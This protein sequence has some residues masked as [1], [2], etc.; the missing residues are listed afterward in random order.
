MP[1]T[2]MN[3]K[4]AEP[5]SL[6][7]TNALILTM[8]A[9]HRIFQDAALA[10]KGSE[11]ADIG[12]TDAISAHYQSGQII[13]ASGC[14]ILPGL[15]NAHTHLPMSYFKGV[16]DDLPLNQ[17]LE[18]NIWPLE[19]QFVADRGNHYPNFVYDATLHG[20]AELI[21]NGVTFANDMYFKTE[22]I[23]S[24]LTKA[25]VRG[26]LG[27]PV[28]A[29]KSEEELD[30]VKQR[31]LTVRDKFKD[32]PLIDI[33]LAPH[34]I[35]TASRSALIKC[36]EMADHYGFPLHIHLAEPE[37]ESAYSL[38]HFGKLPVFYLAELGLLQEKLI[39]AHCIWLQDEEIEL[40]AEHK[41]NVD[42]ALCPESNTKLANGFAPLKKY[43]ERGILCSFGTDSVAS[44]N[45]LDLLSELDFT[46]KVQKTLAH[47]PAF[48]TAEILLR[49]AT[50]DAAKAIGKDKL[51]GSLE[52]GKK[53]DFVIMDC[54]GVE[55]QPLYDPY[56]QVV[57]ALGG[58]AVR[59]VVINGTLV[60]KNKRLTLLDE[61][62]LV[63]KA[64]YYQ[65]LINIAKVK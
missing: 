30:T 46:A 58:R 34:S 44:N 37:W 15:I 16:A 36:A 11:I 50:L 8:D 62:E 65:K 23:A 57:Y 17:W 51:L 39:L 9:Q 14:I 20:A 5:V 63:E 64:R 48:L 56:S 61:T 33:A 21:K 41:N 2:Q 55:G 12:T 28:L 19:Q 4:Q 31:A 35:Y 13:D 24:A 7:V 45:N 3:Q 59:D 42:I 32:N 40:L 38:E 49:M 53:A 43:I 22:Q 52:I 60:Y 6:L 54:N 29:A 25:G 26:L 18:E 10:I 1:E 47:D 27:E